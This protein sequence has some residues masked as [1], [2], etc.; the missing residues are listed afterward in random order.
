M[1]RLSLFALVNAALAQ[2]TP[3][4][5]SSG[6]TNPC[7]KSSPDQY[8]VMKAVGIIRNT[9]S[10][11]D[12]N[13]YAV[14][15]NSPI[16]GL[17][18]SQSTI[19][20]I[21]D[22]TSTYNPPIAPE[23]Y[24][25]ADSTN[26]PS[27]PAVNV[28]GQSVVAQTGSSLSF[29]AIY[30]V[31]TQL[32]TSYT[33]LQLMTYPQVGSFDQDSY[34]SIVPIVNSFIGAFQLRSGAPISITGSAYPIKSTIDPFIE[35]NQMIIDA[36]MTAFSVIMKDSLNYYCMGSYS[37]YKNGQLPLSKIKD[38]A[39]PDSYK[40]LQS[41]TCTG[42]TP[43]NATYTTIDNAGNNVTNWFIFYYTTSNTITPN[44]TALVANVY[45]VFYTGNSYSS[46]TGSLISF[47]STSTGTFG[48][49][50]TKFT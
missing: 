20:Y 18:K 42:C 8:F 32:S 37:T 26:C 19:C 12:C 28:N 24:G 1:L 9:G 27:L 10:V 46:N 40:Y 6:N 45:S 23:L 48:S 22:D 2:F 33:G 36:R 4:M 16:F 25:P 13:N 31:Q 15:V 39:A 44:S 5:S 41:T 50:A 17:Q 3:Y 47:G 49:S 7:F 38:P 29:I 34:G 43:R 30:N 11:V 21:K 35:C 14:A